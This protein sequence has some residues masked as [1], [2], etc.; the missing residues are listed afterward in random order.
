[1]TMGYCGRDRSRRTAVAG[2]E[3]ASVSY[4]GFWDELSAVTG[5]AVSEDE[6]A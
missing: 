6:A 2:A 4:P 1:M 3:A 5:G